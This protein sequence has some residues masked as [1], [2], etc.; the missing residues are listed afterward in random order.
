M[1]AAGLTE[2]PQQDIVRSFQEEHGG[3]YLLLEGPDDLRQLLELVSFANINYQRGLLNF[4]GLLSKLRK[5]ADQFNR[6]IV[7]AVETQILKRLKDRCLTGAGHARNN[8]KL[9]YVC[10]G[11]AAVF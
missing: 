1:G 3:L 7:Y 2:A 11:P 9:G 5:T 8:D 4:R 6:K 10:M